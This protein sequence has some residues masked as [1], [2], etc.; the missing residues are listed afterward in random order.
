ME[1]HKA[2]YFLAIIAL[3]SISAQPV[4][5]GDKLFTDGPDIT[6]SVYGTNEIS[7]GQDTTLTLL[8][9]NKGLIDMKL[10]QDKYM[11]P[12]YLPNT[13]KAGVV[14][15]KSGNSPVA[16]KSDPQVFGDLPSGYMKTV[17][18][19][20]YIPD[21]TKSGD[22]KMTALV[23]YEYM[24]NSQQVGNDAISYTFKKETIEVPVN[25][26]IKPSVF[27]EITDISSESLSAGGEG[28]ITMNIKNAGTDTAK[29]LAI[30]IS[31]AGNSP[32]T[33]VENGV[34]AGDFPPEETIS[35]RFKV[36]ISNDAD[37]KQTYPVLVYG[38]Y[39][40]YE[41]LSQQTESVTI[42]VGFSEKIQFEVSGGP[43]A[44]YAGSENLIHVT[45]KNTGGAT[46]YQAQGRI[47]V[48]DPFSS[49]D[50]NVYLGDMKPGETKD[51]VYKIKVDS[52]A[53]V[54]QYSLDSEIRY[55]DIENNNYVS[56]T[57]KVIIDVSD[58]GAG[59]TI[60]AAVLI[61]LIAALGYII[62]RKK[63]SQ[64]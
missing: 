45:Y 36:A 41:G 54:K 28:Y 7:S 22:Y 43:A 48:V 8:V 11:T 3:I 13:A 63:V 18:F 31:P 60:I 21:N 19:D 44:A 51:A 56:D 47:S 61:I 35:P 55:N 25:I 14:A 39:K 24:E 50:T 57:V 15:L 5:A 20:I 6:I 26:I 27:F 1:I 64:R 16:V 53:T 29:S 33:P 17:S 46:A 4:C 32:V 42:G 49:S 52:G 58:K 38:V 10:V 62:Y 59:T 37:P 30:F 2:L 23:E 34:Y 12:D 40:D 9:Q